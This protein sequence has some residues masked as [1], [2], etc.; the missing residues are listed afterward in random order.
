MADQAERQPSLLTG[1]PGEERGPVECLGLTFEND[2]ARRAYFLERLREKLENPE[3][4]KIEGFPIGS[5]EDILALSDPPYYT[6]CP[7]PFIA[8]FI[9]HH[10]KPYDPNQPYHRE[11]FAADVSEGKNDPI[12]NAHSYHTKVPHKAIM[13]YILHYTEPGDI[14]LDGFCG[15]G[16][17][18]V[19][20][21]L[22]ADADSIRRLGYTVDQDG[23]VRDQSGIFISRI[24]P[25]PIV[26]SD[27]SP[28]ATSIAAGYLKLTHMRSFVHEA[29]RVVDETEKELEDLYRPSDGGSGSVESTIWSDVFICPHCSGE[30]VYWDNAVT[31]NTVL[32]SFNCPHCGAV[33]G[34]AKS[35]SNRADKLLRATVTDFDPILSTTVTL[36]KCVP[37]LENIRTSNGKRQLRPSITH[38]P[39]FA[40]LASFINGLRIPLDEFFPGRQTNKL[41]NGTGIRYV[42]H[43]YTRRALIAYA[44]LFSKRLSTSTSTALFRFSLTAIHNYISKKQGY[45]GGGGGVSGTLFTPSLHLERNVFSAIRR[46]LSALKGI[47]FGLTRNPLAIVSTHSATD[48]SLIP[49]ETID[50]IFT[51][52]PF[53]E[54]IQYTELNHFVEAWLHV[55]TASE[56]DCV[57]NYVHK[58]DLQFYTNTMSRAFQE[59]ARV[60]KRGRWITV[61]FHNS[62]NA[63]WAAIQE[64]MGAAGLVVA[65]VRVLD[66]K[67]R[68]FNAVNRA[69]AVDKDLIISAYKPSGE[70]ETRFM[71]EAG[72]P[73]GIW[74]FVREHLSRLPVVVFKNGSLEV[75]AERQAVLLFDRMVAFHVQRGV[76]VPVSAADFYRGLSERF[77]ERDEMFFLTEQV[78]EY[79]R[80]RMTA[81][82]VIQLDLF[83]S[84]EASAIQW[85]KRQLSAKPQTFMDLQPQFMQ[86]TRGGWQKHERRLELSVLLEENFLRFDGNGEVPSQIHAY[87]SSNF[88]DLRGLPK[89]HPALRAK[90]KD[91]WYV[92]DPAKASDLEKLRE[93][94]LLR[95]FHEYRESKQK[96]LKVFRVEAVRAGFRFAWQHNDY[97]AILAVAEKIPE[98]ILQ[99][100]PML[101]MW[102][103]NSLTRAGQKL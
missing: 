44:T 30:L 42:C 22:C 11:P 8:D 91:R 69:G 79:D 101:L 92:P 3:F 53:G 97:A 72:T 66:K 16:M 78:A 84:D 15:T 99:E 33:I 76:S 65:D 100:D 9:K 10:G 54:S 49:K 28:L 61:E 68:G 7:N 23:I 59:Y 6:A 87:L 89:D 71:L 26:L 46:K 39:S 19:A 27:L 34:K 37:V 51:D 32:S 47:F 102:Y 20:A 75:I 5:D 50:Y 25:R 62:Q 81:R 73:S 35:R 80:K 86:E 45:F 21:Q 1:E 57:L 36:P 56:L 63:V 12:Y 90:A 58:K 31:N 14:V 60:L 41:I 85:L 18:G 70:L 40:S 43:M 77:P 95:E 88:K 13:R 96:K 4:R 83:V 48:L 67:Q 93:R 52:P 38:L 98:D 24:G 74:D 55:R 17:A 103:T 64:S 29:L 2:E 82:E 94:A